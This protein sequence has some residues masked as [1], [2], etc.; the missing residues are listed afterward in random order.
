TSAE[1]ACLARLCQLGQPRVRV[2]ALQVV[3]R[4]VRWGFTQE[5]L[6]ALATILQD[7][8][9]AVRKECCRVI[10]ALDKGGQ[11][12]LPAP[13]PRLA[14]PVEEVRSAAASVLGRL[15]LPHPEAVQALAERLHDPASAVRRAASVALAAIGPNAATEAALI[16]LPGLL[17]ATTTW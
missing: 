7:P 2:Q 15:R 11:P 3:Q 1:L 10:Y 5:I 8:S 6:E 17:R 13:G 12:V 14:E 16:A 4:L 9:D